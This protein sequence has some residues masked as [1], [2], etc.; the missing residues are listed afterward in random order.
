MML[1][2]MGL[3]NTTAAEDT[4]SESADLPFGSCV[5][6]VSWRY[7]VGMTRLLQLYR[8]MRLRRQSNIHVL[9]IG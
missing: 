6:T 4:S 7:Y 1:L 9:S 8:Q 2:G 5:M 3:S